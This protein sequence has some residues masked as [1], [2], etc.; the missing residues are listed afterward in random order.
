[1]ERGRGVWGEGGG[2]LGGGAGGVTRQQM[3]KLTFPD[4]VIAGVEAGWWCL[5]SR[6]SS[7]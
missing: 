1:M 5:T 3:L 6:A 2:E 7:T 4:T